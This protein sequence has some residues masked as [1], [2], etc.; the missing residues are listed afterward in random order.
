MSHCQSC[1]GLFWGR[2]TQ[3]V[4]LTP[5]IESDLAANAMNCDG[6]RVLKRGDVEAASEA[7]RIYVDKLRQENGQWTAGTVPS[8]S[9]VAACQGGTCVYICNFGGEAGP[10]ASEF[11]SVFRRLDIAC[12]SKTSVANLF[13]AN[14]T[15]QWG[16]DIKG[17]NVCPQIGKKDRTNI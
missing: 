6:E 4:N 9:I 13:T 12:G 3:G 16:R 1:S 14:N 11:L 5:G 7:L 10:L 17:V 15:R 8:A 2:G